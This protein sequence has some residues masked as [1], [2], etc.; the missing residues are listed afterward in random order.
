VVAAFDME[1]KEIWQQDL[2]S[3][4]GPFGLQWGYASSPLLADGK[5][6]VPL[7]LPLRHA[8]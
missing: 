8:S 6:N 1:G 5:L 3:A 4:Y 7:P 2:Q